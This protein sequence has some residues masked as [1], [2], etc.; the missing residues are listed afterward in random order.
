M[1]RQK[2]LFMVLDTE[3]ANSVEE[4]L[5]YDIGYAICDR[6]GNIELTRSFVVAEIFLDNKDLMQSAYYVAKIPQYW[7]DI[8][9]GKRQLKSFY[10]IRRQIKE[11]MKNYNITKVGAYN[12]G[13]DKKALNNDTRYI[14]KSFLRWFF[15]Y[16]TEYFCIWNMACDTILNRPSYIKFAI[17][18]GFVSEKGNIQTSA[19]CAYKYLTKDTDFA[20]CHT[21]L[22]D[23]LI[24]VAIMAYCYRQHKK[25]DNSI[26]SSCWRKVQ[27]AK[28][29]VLTA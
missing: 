26:N 10:F 24:E 17:K 20:E 21:G 5:P 8:K 25:F 1:S 15:P 2:E 13:F 11:D 12:M 27:K 7:E 9:S 18:N 3:T 29:Q 22:E 14:T 6:H 19:E 16:G 23:V 28:K 4:P